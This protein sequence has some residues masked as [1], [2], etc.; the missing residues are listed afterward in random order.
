MDR[1]A[2]SILPPMILLGSSD[3][4]QLMQQEAALQQNLHLEDLHLQMQQQLQLEDLQARLACLNTKQVV[5]GSNGF[6][7]MADSGLP[8]SNFLFG[9]VSSMM[10]GL[11]WQAA[12]CS[13]GPLG[14]SKTAPLPGVT[15][16]LVA[17][18]AFVP[19]CMPSPFPE[20]LIPDVSRTYSSGSSDS[21]LNSTGGNMATDASSWAAFLDSYA[22]D[23]ANSPSCG[24][25]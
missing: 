14:G 25:A 24:L 16:G 19:G 12:P 17:A 23:L 9:D 13:A 22:L 10:S 4:A 1:F 11:S 2:A 7:P 3:S 5:T 20:G 15:S 18:A 6:C 8:N 21:S